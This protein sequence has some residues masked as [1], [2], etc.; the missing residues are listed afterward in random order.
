MI[1]NLSPSTDSPYQ[2]GQRYKFFPPLATF[3]PPYPVAPDGLLPNSVLLQQLRK[4]EADRAM[5]EQWVPPTLS[6]KQLR[7][8][9][10][11]EEV[12]V[13]GRGHLIAL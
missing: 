1:P 5:A 11:M 8:M 4:S 10:E 2:R 7:L 6:E 12:S 3:D 13:G 9:A